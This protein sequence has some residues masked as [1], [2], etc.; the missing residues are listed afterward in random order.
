MANGAISGTPTTPGT[1]YPVVLKVTDSTNPALSA[2]S[3]S[4]T[5]V[6]NP[7]PPNVTCN[8]QTGVYAAGASYSTTCT[9]SGG[10]APY[11][12]S[13]STCPRG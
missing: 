8:P 3:Q 12:W 6:I 10:T 7:G 2:S 9:V 4:L 13:F 11:A 1:S 5:L